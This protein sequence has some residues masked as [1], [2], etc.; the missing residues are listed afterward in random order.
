[1][2]KWA[3]WYDSLPQHTKEYLKGRATW[4]DADLAKFTVAAFILGVILGQVI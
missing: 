3:Q 1:M 4:T 2:N